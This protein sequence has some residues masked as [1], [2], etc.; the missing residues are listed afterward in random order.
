MHLHYVTELQKMRAYGEA[1]GFKVRTQIVRP[2]LARTWQVKIL[3][4]RGVP[5]FA[6][7]SSDCSVDLKV[8]PQRSFRNSLFRKL[9]KQGLKDPVTLIGTRYDESTAR[10]AK[11]S[12]RGDS[13]ETPVLNKHGELVLS[14]IAHWS[15]DD[16][17]EYI[18]MVNSGLIE[19]YTDF[20]ETL[21]LYSHAAGT[22]C[23]M[24]AQAIYE[25]DA[26]TKKNTGCGARHG[27][28]LCLKTEDK[29]LE[30]M[31]AYDERYAYARGLNKL[32]KFLRAT[33]YDWS[34][35]GYV[36]RTIKGEYIEIR[37][38]TYHPKMIREI[39][40]YML[41]LDYDEEVRAA[42][43]GEQRRFHLL[44][45]Q[46]VVALDALQSMNGL[47]RPHQIWADIRDIHV[48]GIRYD[49][50]EI[51]EF[52]KTAMPPTKYL[53]VGEDWES[54]A[55]GSSW[56]GLRDVYA[57]GL[58][59]GPGACTPGLRELKSGATV[60]DVETGPEFEI[61]VESAMMMQEFE[62]DRLLEQFDQARIPGGITAAY[63][64]YVQYGCLSLAPSQVAKHDE[65]LRRTAFKDRLGL[66]LDYD[67]ADL[68][69]RAVTFAELPEEAQFAWSEEKRARAL[70]KESKRDTGKA[71][72]GSA[73]RFLAAIK[74]AASQSLD[75]G[76]ANDMVKQLSEDEP[77]EAVNAQLAL[78]F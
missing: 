8:M 1:H 26:P 76:F 58:T 48:R 18:G 78:T 35:R 17:F 2:S 72:R 62:L 53:H 19:A 33:Q 54:G 15:E 43:A 20:T 31:I 14:S 75:D 37:P 68:Y 59:E 40:R 29:S 42:K 23:A 16:V 70:K 50:P 12:A 39:T 52:P 77:T 71:A 44:P 63:K 69:A 11:M 4:G 38:D 25:T 21:R 74:D 10:A 3:S 7:G 24:V 46:M 73:E 67:V 30:A 36:G 32:N 51:E 57:E 41:Q 45:L 28:F 47:S 27:C 64:W 49:I 22:S 61:D 55:G 66:T 65:V 34:R 56:T 5:S 9:K 13:A 60:W 6:G